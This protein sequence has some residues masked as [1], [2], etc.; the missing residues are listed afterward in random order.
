MR[1]RGRRRRLALDR[2]FVL[3]DHADWP[4]LLNTITE[5]GAERIITTHGSARILARFLDE[6]GFNTEILPTAAWGETEESW[7]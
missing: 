3:S 2:G 4:G 6:R 1:V 5:T 7:Q